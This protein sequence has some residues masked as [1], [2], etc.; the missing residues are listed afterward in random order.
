MNGCNEMLLPMVNILL[1][2]STI[3]VWIGRV[4]ENNVDELW[5]GR[6]NSIMLPSFETINS[7]SSSQIRPFFFLLPLHKVQEDLSGNRPNDGKRF[8]PT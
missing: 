4:G 2:P 6:I 5:K 8:L 7:P 1:R 3:G